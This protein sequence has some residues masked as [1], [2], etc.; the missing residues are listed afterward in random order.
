[1]VGVRR[2]DIQEQHTRRTD[3]VPDTDCVSYLVMKLSV[4]LVAHITRKLLA[5]QL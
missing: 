1:M 2:A 3:G 4:Y 5:G